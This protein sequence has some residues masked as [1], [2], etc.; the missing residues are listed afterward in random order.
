M[1]STKTA[2]SGSVS[3]RRP[4]P[5]PDF[6]AISA[7][8]ERSP[9][10]ELGLP[11]RAPL[12]AAPQGGQGAV[13][14]MD[15]VPA[16]A[17]I[18]PGESIAAARGAGR[19]FPAVQLL[20]VGVLVA[21]VGII[22][23]Y[24]LATR[25]GTRVAAGSELPRTPGTGLVAVD[26]NPPG[27]D[28]IVDGV[29]RGATPLELSLPIGERQIEIRREDRIRTMPVVVSADRAAAHFVDFAPPAS[30]DAKPTGR[31]EITSEPAG[32]SVRIDGV[33]RGTTPLA[34]DD[35]AAGE[36]RIV[37][38]SDTATVSRSVR[39]AA[40]GIAS[41][42]VSMSTSRA[43]G[44]GW[45]ALKAPFDMEIFQDGRLLGTTAAERLMLPAG[46]HELELVNVPLAFRTR[47]TVTVANGQT[48]TPSITVPNGTLS[49]NALPWA[50]VWIGDRLV[51]TTPLANVSVPIGSHEVTYRHPQLGERRAA[52][53]VTAGAPARIGVD[54]SR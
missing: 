46:R 26:S 12:P 2:P 42:M 17:E 41:V 16:A 9:L 36:R 44:A 47:V 33:A 23:A 49:I 50:E 52:V 29:R 51:G 3:P 48:V 39:V 37:L 30:A 25:S 53:M 28:V 54:L 13:R 10:G 34:L 43:A 8:L 18:S 38:T 40:G 31:L 19:R 22:T 24:F 20:A 14:V 35:V 5:A 11:P 15:A 1:P 32:A 6:S 45:V 7:D 4:P 21:V 27:A